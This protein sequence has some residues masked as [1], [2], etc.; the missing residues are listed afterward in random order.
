VPKLKKPTTEDEAN[1]FWKNAAKWRK[2]NSEF[3][4]WDDLYQI[5]FSIA[6]V[7]SKVNTS[8]ATARRRMLLCGVLIRKKGMY[9]TRILDILEHDGID[10]LAVCHQE[11]KLQKASKRLGVHYNVLRSWLLSKG[12]TGVFKR[13]HPPIIETKVEEMRKLKFQGYSLRYIGEILD[14]S[15]Y[16]VWKYCRKEKEND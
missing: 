6:V 4:M 1:Q 10:V 16:S 8:Y 9:R 11:G 12:L 13:G 7:A 15:H 2:Y 3:E 14:V 5:P